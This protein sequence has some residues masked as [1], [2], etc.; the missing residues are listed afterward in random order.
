MKIILVTELFYCGQKIMYNGLQFLALQNL[1]RDKT[2]PG[3]VPHCQKVQNFKYKQ[4]TQRTT[5][6]RTELNLSQ[7]PFPQC[8]NRT[9]CRRIYGSGHK[10]TSLGLKAPAGRPS[11]HLQL[12]QQPLHDVQEDVPGDSLQPLAIFLD[13]AC[14]GQDDLVGHDC[15]GTGHG[16]QTK[17]LQPGSRGGAEPSNPLHPNATSLIN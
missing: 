3:R 16:L 2:I 1:K 11:T 5:A 6:V 10:S 14:D 15:V 9:I 8:T 17:A 13:Q 4:K 7:L 12:L